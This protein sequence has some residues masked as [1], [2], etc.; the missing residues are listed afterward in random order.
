MTRAQVARKW[1]DAFKRSR[2]AK[3]GKDMLRKQGEVRAWLHRL[4][5]MENRAK[6]RGA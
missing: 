4:M 2:N 1:A 5:E 6:R 3:P